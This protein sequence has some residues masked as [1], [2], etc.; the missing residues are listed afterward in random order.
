MSAAAAE[1]GASGVAEHVDADDFVLGEAPGDAPPPSA[2]EAAA[3]TSSAPAASAPAAPS[4][5]GSWAAGAFKAGWFFV[6]LSATFVPGVLLRQI[7]ITS[8]FKHWNEIRPWLY[9]GALP[10]KSVHLGRGNHLEKL[11]K[12]LDK[13]RGEE[14]PHVMGLVVSCLTPEEGRGF[15]VGMIEFVTA[16]AW[17]EKFP[18]VQTLS[19]SIVDMRADVENAAIYDATVAMHACYQ[20]GKVCYVH[21]KA[22]KGRS[23]MVLMCYLVT[24]GGMTFD[25]AT[26]LVKSCRYQVDPSKSQRERVRQFMAYV[27]GCYSGTTTTADSGTKSAPTAS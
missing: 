6:T 15:G 7:G 12:Q 4:T 26:S 9:L 18:G 20:A 22:G 1:V 2:E 19:L 13:K 24:F 3:A 8:N 27:E 21:C 25:A 10:V 17:K 23:W 11:A 14:E 16:D 5:V